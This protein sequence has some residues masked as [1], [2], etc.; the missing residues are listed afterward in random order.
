ML[1]KLFIHIKKKNEDFL[2]YKE[3]KNSYSKCKLQNFRN[4]K[5]FSE[6]ILNNNKYI[7]VLYD[8][9]INEEIS[10][11]ISNYQPDSYNKFSHF[12]L[13]I[14]KNLNLSEVTKKILSLFYN[15]NL[16]KITIFPLIEK[17]PSFDYEILLYSH[18]F[19]VIS[20]MS[21]N[22]SFYS[23]IISQQILEYLKDKYV[24]GGE[25]N[26]SL[27]IESGEKKIF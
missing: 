1:I 18:K 27:K 5:E 13:H 15:I 7:M 19:S 16:L 17:L 3:I 20:S 26:D 10:N 9:I 6:L 8:L 4:I 2:I 21:N 22:E 14:L 24:P 12:I 25:P 11:L 23:K